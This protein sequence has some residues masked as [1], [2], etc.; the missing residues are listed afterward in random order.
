[1]NI[2]KYIYF[3]IYII[4]VNYLIISH[5]IHKYLFLINFNT[6]KFEKTLI[7]ERIKKIII[8]KISYN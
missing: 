1:M 2:I 4:I 3:Y 6:I 8:F 5:K 7:N